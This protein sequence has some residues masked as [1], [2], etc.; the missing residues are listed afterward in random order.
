MQQQVTFNLT[1]TGSYKYSAPLKTRMTLPHEQRVHQVC[2]LLKDDVFNTATAGKRT[3]MAAGG[4]RVEKDSL[5]KD[6]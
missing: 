6:K 1:W 5:L 4:N 3:K 2:Y